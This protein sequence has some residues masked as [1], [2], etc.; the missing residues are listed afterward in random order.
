[1]YDRLLNII[2][3]ID[4]NSVC[5]YM[6]QIKDP[7]RRYL[8]IMGSLHRLRLIFEFLKHSRAVL[9]LSLRS[10]Q[11]FNFR[12]RK[13]QRPWKKRYVHFH[14]ILVDYF[15]CASVRLIGAYLFCLRNNNSVLEQ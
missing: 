7:A 14:K 9:E 10:R 11:G 15:Y 12:A 2:T 13:M 1:M 8:A 6:G 3:V 5:K 4:V